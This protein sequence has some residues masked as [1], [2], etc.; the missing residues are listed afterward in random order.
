MAANDTIEK[1]K[2][3]DEIGFPEFTAKLINSTF[4][5]LI[6]ANL[7][8]VE[9]YIGLVEQVSKTLKDYVN[10]TKDDIG[11]AEVLQFLEAVLPALATNTENDTKAS[12]A[13]KGAT[14]NEDEATT[15]TNALAVPAEVGPSHEIQHGVALEDDEPD[16]Q[17]ASLLNAVAQRISV[18]KYNML[19]EMVKQGILRLV[20][21]N[22]TI[23]T[24]MTFTTFATSAYT[25]DT[26]VYQR[27]KTNKRSSAGAGFIFAPFFS[28]K[29][30][31]YSTRLIVRT[32]KETQQDNSGSRVNIFGAVTI[33][34]KTDYQPLS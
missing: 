15:L 14:L 5:A 1:A 25:R 10:D 9:S 28:A 18:N 21:T 6:I 17:W 22:G 2:R 12:R 27:D 34:F 16:S 8:Q 29:E 30:R 33:N 23:E 32:T 31:T 19:Q 7:R 11:G 26:T 20:V 13:I 4:E 24:R 3:L